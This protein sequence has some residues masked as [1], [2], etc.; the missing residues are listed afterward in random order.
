MKGMLRMSVK[1]RFTIKQAL[2]HPYFDT[3]RHLY[4][5]PTAEPAS[6]HTRVDTNENKRNGQQ[7]M[8]ENRSAGVG[9]PQNNKGTSIKTREENEKS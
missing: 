7:E 2:D 6:L 3:V 9:A 5:Y 8:D 4:N 1:E